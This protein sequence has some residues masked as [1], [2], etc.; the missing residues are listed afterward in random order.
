MI[1]L[2]LNYRAVMM[3]VLVLRYTNSMKAILQF[4]NV[5]GEIYKSHVGGKL[6]RLF[7]HMKN[8]R[9]GV[10]TPLGLSDEEDTSEGLGQ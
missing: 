2:V 1:I 3:S 4:H 5:M 10:Q 8:T 7:Y 6:Y 9:I